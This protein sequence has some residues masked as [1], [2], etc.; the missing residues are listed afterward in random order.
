MGL[1]EELALYLAEEEYRKTALGNQALPTPSA[2]VPIEEEPSPV[3]YLSEQIKGLSER[4]APRE[5]KNVLWDVVGSGL[6]SLLDEGLFG[7]PGALATGLG[8]ETGK[9][10]VEYMQPT[11]TA[12][13][14]AAG[15]GGTIGFIKGAPIKLG[16]KLAKAAASPY[17]KKA[18]YETGASV[19]AK[20]SA[21]VKAGK[22]ATTTA[23]EQFHKD[24]KRRVGGIFEQPK[25]TASIK[26]SKEFVK[27]AKIN[28]DE[29]VE[30]SI[31]S[32]KIG[33]REGRA[34]AKAYKN[35]ITKRPL[36]DFVDLFTRN[37]T[38]R[39][40]R[41]AGYMVHEATMFA[42]IDAIHEG[43][44]SLGYGEEYDPWAPVWG[45]GVGTGFGAL[46]WFNIGGKQASTYQDFV[47]GIKG[48]VGRSS[49]KALADASDDNIIKMAQILGADLKR[50]GSSKTTVR[51]DYKGQTVDVDLNAWNSKG[52]ISIQEASLKGYGP[53]REV[54]KPAEAAILRS[55]LNRKGQEL[56]P[57]MVKWALKSEAAQ[58]AKTWPL[59]VAGTAIMNARSFYEWG[60]G[61][62]LNATDVWFN[63]ILG[64]FL[65][66]RGIPR[67]YDA[68]GRTMKAEL[69]NFRSQLDILGVDSKNLFQRIP[70]F[71]PTGKDP[72]VNPI[73]GDPELKAIVDKMDEMGMA[74]ETVSERATDKVDSGSLQYVSTMG[75]EDFS[76]FRAFKRYYEVTSK[77]RFLVIDDMISAADARTVQDMIKT[78]NKGKL[79]R[80]GKVSS[81]VRSMTRERKNLDNRAK[82]L[83]YD[84]IIQ[85]STLSLEGK[86]I[87]PEAQNLYN[88]YVAH[89]EKLIKLSG[90]KAAELEDRE[91]SLYESFKQIP[92]ESTMFLDYDLTNK[93]DKANAIDLLEA[94]RIKGQ[95]SAAD[96]LLNKLKT[97]LKVIKKNDMMDAKDIKSLSN[98]I[99]KAN[100][101]KQI[102]KYK[103]VGGVSNVSELGDYLD[104][105]VVEMYENFKG[106]IFDIQSSALEI[107]GGY[108]PGDKRSNNIGDV[109]DGIAFNADSNLFQLGRDGKL[110]WLTKNGEILKGEDAVEELKD[111]RIAVNRINDASKI[112]FNAKSDGSYKSIVDIGQIEAL[113]NLVRG[114]ESKFN[115]EFGVTRDDYKFNFS[116]MDHIIGQ[117]VNR[118]LF[119]DTRKLNEIFDPKK[120]DWNSFYSALLN[121]KIIEQDI[122]TGENLIIDDIT[123]IKFKGE[124]PGE[125]NQDIYVKERKFLH[126][127]Q[128]LVRAFNHQEYGVREVKKDIEISIENLQG[129][130]EVLKSLGMGH[131]INNMEFF[132]HWTTEMAYRSMQEKLKNTNLTNQDITYIENL[133]FMKSEGQFSLAKYKGIKTGVP[134]WEIFKIST[135]D[136][137]DD[138]K[139]IAQNHNTA[140]EGIRKRSKGVVTIS[141]KEAIFTGENGLY[142]INTK[143]ID[144]KITAGRSSKETLINFLNAVEKPYGVTEAI[145][146]ASERN[147]TDEMSSTIVRWLIND[148]LIVPQFANG[149]FNQIN[150]VSRLESDKYRQKLYE[151][152]SRYDVNVG[153]IS[154]IMNSA[155][156]AAKEVINS[157]YS[158]KTDQSLTFNAFKNRYLNHD[159]GLLSNETREQ[160]QF[161][162]DI[163]FDVDGMFRG[164]AAITDLLNKMEFKPDNI[165]KAFDDAIQIMVTRLNQIE[166]PILSFDRGSPKYTSDKKFYKT[167]YSQLM[168]DIDVNWLF[169]NPIGKDYDKRFDKYV[170]DETID[171]FHADSDI[172][173]KHS[174]GQLRKLRDKYM[175]LLD[176]YKEGTVDINLWEGIAPFRFGNKD[177]VFG[178]YRQD[179]QNI[180]DA[181]IELKNRY[182]EKASQ[183]AKNNFIRMEEGLNEHVNKLSPWH[184]SALRV[185]VAERMLK[186]KGYDKVLEYIEAAPGS[187]LL[188]DLNRR[189]SLFHPTSA[190]RVDRQFVEGLRDYLKNNPVKNRSSEILDRYLKRKDREEIRMAVWSDKR[191]EDLRDEATTEGGF[192]FKQLKK[193][194]LT[195]DDL[196]SNRESESGFDSITYISK[197]FRDYLHTVYGV[198][199]DEPNSLKPIITSLGKDIHFLG[200]TMF[201]YS[202]SV[203]EG[204]FSKNKGLDILT[205]GTADK[206]KSL[207][208]NMVEMSK[209]SL[210]GGADISKH[211]VNLPLDAI[212]IIKTTDVNKPASLSSTLYNYSGNETNRRVY[213]G[214][215]Q[216]DVFAAID[217]VTKIFGDPYL[218]KEVV[219][220][221]TQSNDLDMEVVSGSSSDNFNI[222]SKHMMRDHAI[223]D[224][225]GDN[226]VMN[227][228]KKKY[229]DPII[230]PSSEYQENGV[231]YRYGGQAPMIQD[232]KIENY[233]LEP[234]LVSKTGKI[235]QH[236]EIILPN[237][238]RNQPIEFPGKDL[239]VNVISKNGLIQTAREYYF[240]KFKNEKIE[241]SIIEESWNYIVGSAEP[242]GTLHDIIKDMSKG[243]WQ[244]GVATVRYP[245]TRQN[246]LIFLRVKDFLHKD[247]GEAVIVNKFDVLNV[248][249]G[250]YD[251]DV[252]NFFWGVNRGMRDHMRKAGEKW[253]HTISEKSFPNNPKMPAISLLTNDASSNERKWNQY[254]S[255]RRVVDKIGKG[256]VQRNGKLVNFIRSIARKEATER[257]GVAYDEYILY[258]RQLKNESYK[259]KLIVDWDLTSWH[260][261]IAWEGQQMLDYVKGLDSDLF[262]STDSYRWGTLLP[263]R[264]KSVGREHFLDNNGQFS[265]SKARNYR[266]QSEEGSPGKSN[267][268]IRIFRR[269]IQE[270]DGRWE[271]ADLTR[272]DRELLKLLMKRHNRFLAIGGEANIEGRR[273]T[274]NYQET[275]DISKEYFEFFSEDN[276]SDNLYRGVRDAKEYNDKSGDYDTP[277]FKSTTSSE[278]DSYFNQYEYESPGYKK[279]ARKARKEG[280]FVDPPRTSD[281][282]AWYKEKNVLDKSVM[283]NLI[284][285]GKGDFGTPLERSMYEFYRTN[286]LQTGKDK[287]ILR[288]DLY[289]KYME[290]EQRLMGDDHLQM[291]EIGQMMPVIVNDLNIAAA[292]IKAINWTMY[293]VN[294]DTRQKWTTKKIKLEALEA[295]KKKAESKIWD[296]LPAEYKKDRKNKNLPT[297]KFVEISGEREQIRALTQSWLTNYITKDFELKDG[298]NFRMTKDIQNGIRL[299]KDL[300]K[301]YYG[302]TLTEPYGPRTILDVTQRRTRIEQKDPTEIQQDI[303]NMLIKLYNDYDELAIWKFA[304]PD[305][306][307]RPSKEMFVGIWNGNVTNMVTKPSKRFSLAIKFFEKV[308]AK[309]LEGIKDIDES[310]VSSERLLNMITRMY[311]TTHNYFH[312]NIN[313][314]PKD[315][316]EFF[317]RMEKFAPDMPYFMQSMFR[318]YS[319]IKFNKQQNEY[320]PFS[321]GQRKNG[322]MDFFRRLFIASGQE[323][324]F[325]EYTEGLSKLSQ[326]SIEN[327]LMHPMKYMSIMRNIESKANEV[328]EKVFTSTMDIQTGK[329]YP[330]PSSA[331]SNNP[332]YIL[333]GGSKAK[334]YGY[335]LNSARN[336]TSYQKDMFKRLFDQGN[337]VLESKTN[338]FKDMMKEH[339]MLGKGCRRP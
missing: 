70:T 159:K 280:E 118:E 47:Q 179:R 45:A 272:A 237:D 319:E 333:L 3:S 23:G 210:M 256:L 198:K 187:N 322:K 236:G 119:T 308:A 73:N 126:G 144:A 218:A 10:F 93:I 155:Q 255:N 294:N 261:R 277:V 71:D 68:G 124:K 14:I 216:S 16:S 94:Y 109:P 55:A 331:F 241:E 257:N 38:N 80:I 316:I 145:R 69:N 5:A 172:I 34:I 321:L 105:S 264:N 207:K 180:A 151:R 41:T 307:S 143:L 77:K 46:K 283:E 8:G 72:I 214:V 204:V 171:L 158:F 298:S 131:K 84:D 284:A 260:E 110:K 54:G 246:D 58:I 116:D 245:R 168:N 275:I 200:K 318:K 100:K 269:Y 177:Q 184:L 120:D 163:M 317:G 244:V 137:R 32:G 135:T 197:E 258:E 9:E 142:T 146:A 97:E 4:E 87:K 239:D 166:K 53:R 98:S 297:L 323:D 289:A 315:D 59:M 206:L 279:Y 194:N 61:Q 285:L 243:D 234:T 35:N 90:K 29:F 293:N 2:G 252:S 81:E 91:F 335:S 170:I 125:A 101:T 231:L 242:L 329:E 336:F 338:I 60:Q 129:L 227:L 42:G 208:D 228:L 85:I 191:F 235:L 17:I 65:N 107:I 79:V 130:K 63:I 288:G 230:K 161:L 219:K 188:A 299:Y 86:D 266:Y 115:S 312:K 203:Q 148:G 96:Y 123:R 132:E 286:P 78:L 108:T 44:H 104:N 182:Y 301:E 149:E 196:L 330:I 111:L 192:L 141:N 247:F 320:N 253:L 147:K 339:E 37:T 50:A 271:E 281:M 106:S 138:L 134:G 251:S 202:P 248:Q 178:I 267:K 128:R 314:I 201:V 328:M 48:F 229:I 114:T 83:G 22:K 217:N 21:A 26:T 270:K 24:L 303:E 186:G 273:K 140:V 152:L 268:K 74:S 122:V 15:V 296:L 224:I 259:S 121:S 113:Y 117:I 238:V 89:R 20:S 300:W 295:S 278:L 263:S 165:N 49:R 199:A 164:E 127:V 133:V 76:L 67:E 324:M 290:L 39:W 193:Y 337:Q 232:M 88:E 310:A 190:K 175:E 43:I 102:E 157:G 139:F 226:F 99:D 82:K 12:G 169:I 334:K 195:W 250:D 95:T 33:A 262:E 173:P 18:G 136:I 40:A 153:A 327:E 233:N 92:E 27:H 51:A 174:R 326:L 225:F 274:P 212:G 1:R 62:E 19:L 276:I 56:G 64:A 28:I 52:N 222:M 156:I 57:Q 185:L 304:A 313:S 213:E 154:D 176:G 150:K 75:G 183:T 249:E 160:T 189:F 240:T 205:T 305:Y 181:F 30:A 11:T 103:Q 6:W 265:S 167:P 332:I 292:Q 215:Y 31:A 309:R 112:L 221:L 311:S 162:R 220:I 209:E 211:I 7:V 306:V 302:N 13:R 36:N 282:R 66:R 325:T 25:I 287:Y 291:D 254:D 223:P